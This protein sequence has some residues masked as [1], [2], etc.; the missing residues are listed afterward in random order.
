MI[1][2]TA[3]AMAHVHIETR[4]IDGRLRLVVYD[5]E[6]GDFAPSDYGFLV[7]LAARRPIP[8]SLTNL[9]GPAGRRVSILPQID[10]GVLPFLGIGAEGLAPTQ[11][12]GGTVR[13]RLMRVDGPGHFVVWQ[14]GPFG[15]AQVLFNSGDGLGASDVMTLRAGPGAHIHANFAFGA[16]G[17]Y[18]ITFRAEGRLVGG[19]AVDS[20]ETTY[21]F[22][23]EGP[24]APNLFIATS[25][26]GIHL[27][28]TNSGAGI[29]FEH[30]TDLVRWTS[31]TNLPAGSASVVVPGDT[32]FRFYRAIAEE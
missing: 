5:F 29:R 26:N 8:S 12:E 24:P 19:A 16:P 18:A 28:A 4:F 13:L 21:F 1:A 6:S 7:P 14:T 2:M 30:S 17:Q 10:D 3:I 11:F 23:V 31:M 25:T 32:G 22:A 27:S 15:D 9:L 20:E